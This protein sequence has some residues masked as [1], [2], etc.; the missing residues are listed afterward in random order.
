MSYF[1][2]LLREHVGVCTSALCTYYAF[3]CGELVKNVQLADSKYKHALGELIF[4][5]R[6]IEVAIALQPL[7]FP[8]PLALEIIDALLPSK[9]TMHSKWQL[10]AAVKHFCERKQ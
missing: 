6:T 5:R 9:A 10:L 4:K 2:C 1:Q 7:R 3:C 8:V